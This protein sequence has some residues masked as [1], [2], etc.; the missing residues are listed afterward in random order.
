M[1][2][3]NVTVKDKMCDNEKTKDRNRILP[4][5]GEKVNDGQMSPVG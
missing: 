2:K 5:T 4:M 3:K 1:T